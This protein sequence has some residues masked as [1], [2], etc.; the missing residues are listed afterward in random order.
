M[1]ASGATKSLLDAD[2][3]LGPGSAPGAF[4]AVLTDRWDRIGGGPLGGYTLA[5]AVRAI[6]TVAEHPDPIVVSA[7][8]LKPARHGP[9]EI[10]TASIRNGRRMS[11]GSATVCQDGVPVLHVTATCGDLDREDGRTE[12]FREPPRL[13]DPETCVDPLDGLD[14]S[15]VTIAERVEYRFPELPG[16]RA[17]Q[18][19]GSP[20]AEFWMRLGDGRPADAVA[21]PLLVDACA[22]MVLELGELTSSTVHLT[23]SMF[24]RATPGWLACRA[25]T[26]HVVADHHDEDFEIW[27]RDGRLVARS[28]QHAI[29]PR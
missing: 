11:T 15:G 6:R 18:P 3:N 14:M 20:R 17:G 10:E 2:T 8:F 29:L 22:P 21:L 5:V 19:T 28:H 27:H 16:W 24:Q 13:P 12:H 9:V 26:N 4:R 7:H 23:V 1:T 25:R